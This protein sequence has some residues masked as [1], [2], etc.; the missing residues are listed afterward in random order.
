L[1]MTLI[2]TRIILLN[3]GNLFRFVMQRQLAFFAIEL[4]HIFIV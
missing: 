1:H 2:K 3:K 4:R